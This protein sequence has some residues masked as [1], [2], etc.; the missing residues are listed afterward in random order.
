MPHQHQWPK[1]A[2]ALLIANFIFHAPVFAQNNIETI[3][4]SGSRFEENIERVPA[5][6]QVITKEQIKQ[7]SSTNLAE[8]LQQ[9]GNVPMSN[10]SGGLLGIGATP[11]L[12]G[13]GSTASSSTLILLNGV[14]LN[15][16]D[17]QPASLNNIPISSIERVEIINGGASVQYGNNAIGGVINIITKEGANLPSQ[18]SISYGSYG[19]IIADAS[20]LKKINNTSVSIFANSSQTN[21]WRENSDALSNSIIARL[22]Q[23]FGSGDKVFIEANAFHNQASYPY[24][25]Y[26]QEVGKGDSYFSSPT[27]KGNGFIQDGSSL[28]SGVSKELGQDFL[29]EMEA[30]YGGSSALS[31]QNGSSILYDKRQLDLTPRVKANWGEWGSTIIGYDYNNSDG[32]QYLPSNQFGPANSSHVNLKNQSIYLIERLPISNNLDLVGGVRRQKQDIS[33]STIN[34]SDASGNPIPDGNYLSSFNAN[35]YDIALNYN[36]NEGH[37]FYSK[38]NQSYRFA[39]TDEY[40]SFNPLTGQNIYSGA[41]IRPQINK[42]IE[43]GADFTQETSKFNISLFQ[44]DSHDEIRPYND[45]VSGNIYNINDD[46]IRRTGI[47][48]NA[49]SEYINK[50]KI[51][52]NFRYQRA[53]YSSGLNNGYLVSLVPKFLFNLNARYQITN[54]IGVGG[55][56]NYTY[57]QYYDGD[58]QNNYN[59]IPSYI[60]GD[61]YADYKLKSWEARLIIKNVSNAVYSVY[62]SNQTYYGG[63]PYNYLPA[64]PRTFFVSLKYNF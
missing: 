13:Y 40:Y 58:L 38:Y 39:N 55:V 2:F 37:R 21:G 5:N 45:L 44:T 15:P 53:V 49:S 41:I 61:V 1:L 8:V 23:G 52:A 56:L 47:N 7:S 10:Q 33:L 22:T 64:P 20:I 17:Q 57:S 51:G 29:F 46:D 32:S 27:N 26:G 18:V 3:V 43:I 12:G 48:L 54:E 24:F 50:L 62:G 63:S 35:A 28:R 19:S 59:Q 11:D 6:I 16:I 30:A 31:P 4:V 36:T 60:F 25:I 9:V 14:R 34:K 42:T